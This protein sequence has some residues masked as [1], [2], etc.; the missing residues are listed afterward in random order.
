VS[1]RLMIQG[2]DAGLCVDV[3]EGEI[4]LTAACGWQR[5]RNEV[6][7]PVPPAEARRLGEWLILHA[8]QAGER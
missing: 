8:N 3:F 4:L 7:V 5:E 1:E 6:Q 2:H